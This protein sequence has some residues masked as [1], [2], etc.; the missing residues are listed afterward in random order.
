MPTENA[1][2]LWPFSDQFLIAVTESLIHSEH[3]VMLAIFCREPGCFFFR[4]G[5]ATNITSQSFELKPYWLALY[6]VGCIAE[7]FTGI[8]LHPGLRDRA[9]CTTCAPI[10]KHALFLSLGD[11]V[12]CPV[13]PVQT[14][15]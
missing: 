3:F 6:A 12:T 13:N 1:S 7:G 2:Y 9:V 4:K 11:P 5:S 15:R 14:P 8:C 10:F